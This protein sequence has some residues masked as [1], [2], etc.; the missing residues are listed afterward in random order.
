MREDGAIARSDVFQLRVT[1]TA[2]KSLKLLLTS[3]HQLKPLAAANYQKVVETIGQV[4]A[5]LFAGDLV[6]D[7]SPPTPYPW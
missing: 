1:P 6:S 2:G 4:D 5:V 7:I 3:D